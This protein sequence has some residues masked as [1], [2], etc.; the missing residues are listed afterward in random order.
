M[1]LKTDNSEPPLL[2]SPPNMVTLRNVI[3]APAEFVKALPVSNVTDSKIQLTGVED[4]L[5]DRRRQAA[6]RL[7][8]DRVAER[9]VR[10]GGNIDDSRKAERLQLGTRGVDD[11]APR[12]HKNSA[13]TLGVV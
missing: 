1:E 3:D 6:V 8:D 5:R 4:V 7:A 11:E 9:Q 13:V 2:M 10:A 12:R